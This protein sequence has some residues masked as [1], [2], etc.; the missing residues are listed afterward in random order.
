MWGFIWKRAWL[1]LLPYP[2]IPKKVCV[3]ASKHLSVRLSLWTIR[4]VAAIETVLFLSASDDIELAFLRWM[5][6]VQS[7]FSLVWA[8]VVI[9]CSTNIHVGWCKFCGV[10]SSLCLVWAPVKISWTVEICAV[11]SVR[12]CMGGKQ[13]ERWRIFC[14]PSLWTWG[15]GKPTSLRTQFCNWKLHSDCWWAHTVC[16]FNFI[17]PLHVEK[18]WSNT[19]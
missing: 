15:E 12:W 1:A 11:G 4:I 16:S 8:P 7:S 13:W 2:N 19:T 10:Q 9:T 3:S 17:L 6:R 5:S 14:D 18:N